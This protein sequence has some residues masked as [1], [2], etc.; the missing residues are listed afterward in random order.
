MRFCR[1]L[2]QHGITVGL[3]SVL[4]AAEGLR[5]VDPTD[6]A[7]FGTLLCSTLVSSKEELDRFWELFY[8]FFLNRAVTEA[9]GP[10][11]GW[12]QREA[13]TPGGYRSASQGQGPSPD[14]S[15]GRP[16][17]M[18]SPNRC[19]IP[20]AT[21]LKAIG[22]SKP[23]KEALQ[24]LI[25]A[26]PTR[27]S[28]RLEPSSLG[29]RF[30]FRRTMRKS[31]QWGGDLLYLELMEP[32][33]KKHRVI[34][35]CDV[36][37]SMEQHTESTLRLA[38]ALMALEKSTEIF[39]FS[40]DLVR[41][42]PLLRGHDLDGFLLELPS[43][44]PQ[45]GSG[46]RIGHCLRCLRQEFGARLLSKRPL[47][48]IHSDGWDKGEIELLRREMS[49]LRRKSRAIIWINPLL[50]TKG[51]EPTCRGMAAALPYLDLFLPP[52]VLNGWRAGMKLVPTRTTRQ[53][54]WVP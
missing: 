18:Y 16:G 17:I 45:W 53:P 50:E 34:F 47:V 3:S 52:G 4:Q 51:Y 11:G 49:W 26:F 7:S 46:T 41:A 27:A 39:L 48:V 24:A 19:W 13:Q 14:V 32:R 36:S 6:L 8:S 44:V 28:R 5:W 1:L 33:P 9:Q 37:G 12:P 25:R 40:T 10:R 35:L 54:P 30:S 43:L 31:L 2:R 15:K 29:S 38:H 21:R 42:T 20:P 22:G 23:L